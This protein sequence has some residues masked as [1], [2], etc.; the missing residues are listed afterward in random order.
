MGFIIFILV[1]KLSNSTIEIR[2]IFRK[3]EEK[4]K[5]NKSYKVS[6]ERKNEIKKEVEEKLKT[7]KNKIIVLFIVEFIVMLFYWYFL[8]AFCHVYTKTQ[9]S[10]ILD[11]I[12][13]IIIDFIVKCFL[14][15]LFAGLYRISIE[16]KDKS[17]FNFVM[18]IYT[19]L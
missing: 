16:S 1:T 5:T 4:I 2:E 9:V 12:L 17:I 3:E 11:G 6:E 19:S 13:S 10:W 7:M 8:T 18:F 15:L 14:C